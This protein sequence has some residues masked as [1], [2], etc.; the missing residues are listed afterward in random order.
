MPDGIAGGLADSEL[1]GP[2]GTL[3]EGRPIDHRCH[4]EPFDVFRV[5]HFACNVVLY[6]HHPRSYDGF[7]S[8]ILQVRL[9]YES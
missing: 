7:L 5:N 8:N 9:L 1:V 4:A 3:R 2:G 6:L